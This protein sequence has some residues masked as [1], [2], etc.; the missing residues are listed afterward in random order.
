[1]FAYLQLPMAERKNGFGLFATEVDN[2]INDPANKILTEHFGKADKYLSDHKDNLILGFF[3][4]D[5][6]T[7]AAVKAVSVASHHLGKR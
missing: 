6:D 3:A 7:C 2:K 5:S 4:R 1:M